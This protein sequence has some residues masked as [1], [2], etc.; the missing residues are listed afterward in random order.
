[1]NEIEWIP[2]PIHVQAKST[3][4]ASSSLALHTQQFE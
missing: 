3:V 4:G 1:M 2:G